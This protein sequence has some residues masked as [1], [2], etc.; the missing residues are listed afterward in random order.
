MLPPALIF[1][2]NIA[3]A[4][5]SLLCFHTTFNIVC[6]ISE[7]N[8]IEILIEISLNLKIALAI[9]IPPIYED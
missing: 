9:L 6:S 4:I 8:T 1:F 2:L 5:W 7:K 3:L